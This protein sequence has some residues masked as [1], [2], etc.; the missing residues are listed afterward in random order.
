MKANAEMYVAHTERERKKERKKERR[1]DRKTDGRTDGRKEGSFPK[2]SV[3]FT[4]RS[5]LFLELKI[6][7]L[8]TTLCTLNLPYTLYYK[9]KFNLLLTFTSHMS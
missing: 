7:F 5:L 8:K 6:S 1:T 2:I 9:R 4:I 3:P